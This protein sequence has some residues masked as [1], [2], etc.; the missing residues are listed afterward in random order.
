MMQWRAGTVVEEVRR[1]AGAAELTVAL[2]E[3]PGDVR[4]M[5]YSAVTGVP[6]PGERVL[7][8]ASALLRGLGTGGL[9]FVVARADV[10]PPDPPAGPGHIVKARY[11][12][13]QQM[14]LAVDEQESPHHRVLAEA[15]DLAGLPVVVA[16]LHSALPAV[17][18]GVRRVRPEA[19]VAYVMTDGGALPAPFSRAVAG[20]RTAGWLAACITVGQAF[21]GDLDAVTVHTGLLAA[22]HVLGADVAVVAQ[23]PGNVG[24]G[25]RWG[26][27]GVAVAEALHAADVLG[28]RGVASLRVSG[29][30]RRARH[31]GVSHHSTTAYGRA[32]LAPADV[33][34]TTLPDRELDARVRAQLAQLVGTAR[35]AL[36]PVEVPADGLLEALRS[37]PVPLATMGRGL[38]ED[39]AP[40][41]LAA[42][43]GSHAASVSARP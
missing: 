33:P 37:S 22:R 35:A 11:T 32:L 10:L 25:T 6:E 28:G 12:P 31:R 24:T 43:A 40:F 16:D 15:D 2:E 38:R 5:A 7:L 39:P 3:T 21:G 29:A 36:T 9:A 30:D 23:G 14:L 8:N 19:T 41:L 18:A 34:V 17:V 4:A 1:W 42:A 13:M 20:L 27:S 26:Y